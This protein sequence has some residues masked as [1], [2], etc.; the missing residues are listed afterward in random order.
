MDYFL[1]FKTPFFPNKSYNQLKDS[2]NLI[3]IIL[4]SILVMVLGLELYNILRLEAYSFSIGSVCGNLIRLTIR[5]IVFSVIMSLLVS[6]FKNERFTLMM[7]L[8]ITSIALLPSFVPLL[9]SYGP[10]YILGLAFSIY[11]YYLIFTGLK[12]IQLLDTKKAIITILVAK[13][14]EV[15]F[16]TFLFYSSY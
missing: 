15:I 7:N 14:C 13:V 16:G 1:I 3:G 10:Y 8:A 11:Y 4:I 12:I 5:L 2:R 6:K 9:I